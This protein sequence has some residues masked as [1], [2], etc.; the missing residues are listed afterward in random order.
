MMHPG[1]RKQALEM[2]RRFEIDQIS[3]YNATK[4]VRKGCSVCQVCNPDNR[5]VKREAQ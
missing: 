4:K 2:Q 3:L 1:V 5:N